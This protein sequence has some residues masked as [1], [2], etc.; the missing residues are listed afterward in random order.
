MLGLCVL[1][2][3]AR[4]LSEFYKIQEWKDTV[5]CDNKRALEQ[6]SHT[7]HRIRPSAKCA[8]IQS[9]IKATKHTFTGK[10]TYLHVY[11]LMD[12]YLLWHQLSLFQQLNCICDM[13]A[14]QAV[15]LAMTQG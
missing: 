13:L 1:H 7:C 10:F 15:T 9:S 6:S 3:F 5:G 2:L 8:D 4:A 12:K 14:K 11:G